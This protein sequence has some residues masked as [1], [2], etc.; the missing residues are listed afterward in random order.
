MSVR[1]RVEPRN[2][3]AHVGNADAFR[4][5]EQLGVLLNPEITRIVH[6]R[7]GF[8]YWRISQAREK[9]TGG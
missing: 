5:P 6:V 4:I 8:D 9:P 1:C 7:F 2:G 3:A